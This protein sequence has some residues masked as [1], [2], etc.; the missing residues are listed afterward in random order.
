MAL[1]VVEATEEEGRERSAGGGARRGAG[2]A[3]GGS[4]VGPDS[5]CRLPF[6]AL[7]ARLLAVV[8]SDARESSEEEAESWQL[9]SGSEQG[10]EEDEQVLHD[11]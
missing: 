3:D 1:K 10:E 6:R 5:L 8:E 2:L 7:L 4:S 11:E 9:H